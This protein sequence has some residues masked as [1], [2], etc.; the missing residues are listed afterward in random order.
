MVYLVFVQAP[1]KRTALQCVVPT[2]ILGWDWRG[3]LATFLSSQ[4]WEKLKVAHAFEMIQA[5][6]ILYG[7]ESIW[8]GLSHMRKN[9][10]FRLTPRA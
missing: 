9:R 6:E 3:N 5:L 7:V 1:G 2:S 8:P 4:H 10:L